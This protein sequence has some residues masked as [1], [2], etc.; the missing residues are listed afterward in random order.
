M[1][2][3]IECDQ[4]TQG[5]WIVKLLLEHDKAQL[6]KIVLVTAHAKTKEEAAGWAKRD[7]RVLAEQG[8]A[9]LDAFGATNVVT[10]ASAPIVHAPHC[11]PTIPTPDRPDGGCVCGAWKSWMT[12]E[13][14]HDA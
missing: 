5:R 10:V 6:K 11:H 3:K 8:F 12:T 4:D 2:I 14:R 7:L 9:L 1:A 13:E